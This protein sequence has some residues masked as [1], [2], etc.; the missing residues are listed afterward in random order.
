MR[1]LLRYERLFSMLAGL[2]VLFTVMPVHECAHGYVACRLGDDTAKN[3]GRLTLNPFRH[4]D[5]F[6]SLLI[7]FAGFGWAKPVVV[8]PRNFKN[9]KRDMALTSL[10]GPASNLLFA[11]LL[12]I[13]YKIFVSLM[14][15]F[16]YSYGYGHYIA[17]VLLLTMIYINLR[18][19]VFNLLPVPPL[20]GSKIFAAV[21][22]ERIYFTLMR[23]ERVIALLLVV[24][25]FTGVL[26]T[27]LGWLT[28]RMYDLLDFLTIPFGRLV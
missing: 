28:D 9:P 22:P 8:D 20:D 2:I 13:V 4:L 12:M 23:Y 3:Q 6:G 17:E 21:L 11:L 25:V 16:R 5:L 15:S 24:L 27:P 14:P 10:A 1:A 26:S 19:A 7:L 18:L